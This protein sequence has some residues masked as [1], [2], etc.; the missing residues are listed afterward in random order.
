MGRNTAKY[1]RDPSASTDE[2]H[3]RKSKS[4]PENGIY[5]VEAGKMVYHLME[6][7]HNIV[8]AC[9]RRQSLSCPYKKGEKGKLGA[10]KFV[11]NQ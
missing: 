10:V 11:R 5:K 1:K 4:L 3:L 9:G 6:W 2:D 7:K 8:I